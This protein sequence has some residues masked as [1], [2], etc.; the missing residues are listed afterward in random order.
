[1][2]VPDPLVVNIAKSHFAHGYHTALQH[3]QDVSGG[4][5]VTGPGGA[6]FDNPETRDLLRRYL[7][8]RAAVAASS[9]CG[10]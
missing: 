4:L 8:G 7:S 9:A 10:R 3:V 6:D 2:F 5:L 1:M